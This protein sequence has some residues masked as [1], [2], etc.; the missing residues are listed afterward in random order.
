MGFVKYRA[1]DYFLGSSLKYFL[2]HSKET[3]SMKRTTLKLKIKHRALKSQRIRADLPSFA[4]MHDITS[5]SANL[6]KS[7]AVPLP[8]SK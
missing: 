5:C 3:N 2:K 4:Y 7:L 1:L 6:R 8:H